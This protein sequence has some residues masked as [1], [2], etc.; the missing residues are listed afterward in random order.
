[1]SVSPSVSPS[2]SLSVSLTT[3]LSVS[4]SVSPSVSLTISP[5]VSLSV[6]PS[7]SLLYSHPVTINDQKYMN[8]KIVKLHKNINVS[9]DELVGPE[10]GLNKTQSLFITFG[11]ET[12]NK[13][14]HPP[15]FYIFYLLNCFNCKLN[16][17]HEK[18]FQSFTKLQET[19]ETADYKKRFNVCVCV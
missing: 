2:V 8:I 18:I 14:C 15:D 10:P 3:S 9:T 12:S 4:P 1:M 16:F 13:V 6:S 7:V 17:Q 19:E 5:S 11:P